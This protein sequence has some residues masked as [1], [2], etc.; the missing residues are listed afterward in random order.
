[1]LRNFLGAAFRQGLVPV[2]PM[3]GLAQT[4]G[5]AAP[6]QWGLALALPRYGI[7]TS[8]FSAVAELDEAM[9]RL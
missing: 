2:G 4:P 9:T 6:N 3:H 5:F 1:M 8:I 7:A